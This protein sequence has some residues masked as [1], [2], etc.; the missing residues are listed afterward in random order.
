M[1]RETAAGEGVDVGGYLPDLSALYRVIGFLLV[2]FVPLGL[3]KLAE[4]VAWL[5]SHVSISV[6]G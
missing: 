5:F 4:I 2:T 3:W 6:G 1:G